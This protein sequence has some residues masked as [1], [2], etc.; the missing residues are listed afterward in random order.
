MIHS[1]LLRSVVCAALVLVG[2]VA[3]RS[4]AQEAD[5]LRKFQKQNQKAAQ[6]AKVL[7]EKNASRALEISAQRPEQALELLRQAREALAAADA[8]PRPEKARLAHT[9]D[10]GFRDVKARLQSK[11]EA[12]R[13]KLAKALPPAPAAPTAEEK[14]FKTVGTPGAMA[15]RDPKLTV[16]PILFQPNMV[17]VFYSSSASVLPVVSPDRRWVRISISGSF[18]I[19]P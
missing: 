10:N 8:L 2:V 18:G 1:S 3:Q 7:V 6:Q 11:A 13:V 4:S 19:F 12:E 5:L 16:R 14:L 9:L 17:P 15:T